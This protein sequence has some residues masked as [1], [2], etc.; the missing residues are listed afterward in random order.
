MNIR[1]YGQVT[2]KAA[3]IVVDNHEIR[4]QSLTG[5]TYWSVGRETAS[6]LPDIVLSSPIAGRKQGAFAYIGEE[7]FWIEGEGRNGTYYNGEKIVVGRRG[8]IRPRI[9]EN[10]DI[11]QIDSPDF[12]SSAGVFILFCS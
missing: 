6:N 3:I 10:G 8:R 7:W 2:K 5:H 1:F 12:A 9:L 4:F 11:L